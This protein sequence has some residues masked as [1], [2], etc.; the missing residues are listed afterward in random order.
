MKN[1]LIRSLALVV[2]ALCAMPA[3]AKDD[4]D[5]QR[6]DGVL[7][8]L[9]ADPTLGHY[10]QAEQALAR[11]AVAR[12]QDASSSE[13][14]HALY[15][16][17][18][19]VDQAR[20]AAQLED[21]Q[22]QVAQLDREHDR[23]L[24]EA[25]RRDAEATRRE[26]ERQRLQNQLAAEETARLQAQGQEYS[27]A[28]EQARAEAEQARKLAQSQS[29]AAALAR[30]Q[31]DL[32][33]R[34]ALAMR[35]RMESMTAKRGSKGMQMTLEDLA[36]DPGQAALKPAARSHMGKL[37][38]FVQGQPGKHIRI[39]GHTDSSGGAATN[40]ALSLRRAQAVRDAL[41]AAGVDASRISTVGLGEAD[42]VASNA[43][44]AGR[45]RNRRVVVI[46]EDR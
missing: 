11:E 5:Y 8:Q 30:H 41:V 35:A 13:R 45:A 25:S 34:A 21:A 39:E 12:L 22:H 37:V 3:I 10:A 14:P 32:A 28:A 40:K 19:R 43:T 44:A 20:A 24:I 7:D 2:L 23:I 33:E 36:F 15:M 6:L 16:A 4:L 1:M 18:R 31:A 29:R 46:L 38:Q 9:A 42:P 26:L 17:E 27:E